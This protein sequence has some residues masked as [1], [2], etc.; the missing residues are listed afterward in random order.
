MPGS[1]VV[2]CGALSATSVS[3]S[4]KG[5]AGALLADERLGHFGERVLRL[6]RREDGVS[7]CL[8]LLPWDVA[9]FRLGRS[10]SRGAMEVPLAVAAKCRR[11]AAVA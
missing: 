8:D 5:E 10:R 3:G 1:V 11:L 2:S 9:A 7:L 6:D 4:C